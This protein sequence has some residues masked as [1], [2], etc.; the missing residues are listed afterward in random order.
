MYLLHS[1]VVDRRIE[2]PVVDIG[3]RSHLS[4]RVMRAASGG[5]VVCA[6]IRQKRVGL[7]TRSHRSSKRLFGGIVSTVGGCGLS[8]LVPEVP[9]FEWDGGGR[10]I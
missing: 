8:Y 1:V 7:W 3:F 9:S 10:V 4:G 6:D 5:S 2:L